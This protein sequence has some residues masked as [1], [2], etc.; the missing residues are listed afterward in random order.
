VSGRGARRVAEGGDAVGPPVPR[1]CPPP[2]R[3]RTPSD[4]PLPAAVPTVLSTGPTIAVN[5][6]TYETLRDAYVRAHPER[7]QPPTA[8]SLAFGSAS[9]LASSLLLYPTDLVRRQVQVQ[10]GGPPSG[11]GGEPRL[12][13]LAVAR[14]ILRR[15]GW[16][17]FYHGFQAEASKVVPGMAVAFGIYELVKG[18]LGI[19]DAT[20][21]R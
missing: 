8:V 13:A 3:P 9:G 20:R 11:A 6:A 12:T 2:A 16:R 18:L 5:Y 15:E 14:A 10:G 1:P 7:V 21:R 19:Q 17:G 4:P